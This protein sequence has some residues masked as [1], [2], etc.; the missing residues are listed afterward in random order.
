MQSLCATVLAGE[1][2]FPGTYSKRTVNFLS[3][4]DKTNADLFSSLCGFG[5]FLGDVVPLVLDDMQPIY[6]ERGINFTTLTYLE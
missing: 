2:N 4:L 5:W 1:A 3:S 6:N